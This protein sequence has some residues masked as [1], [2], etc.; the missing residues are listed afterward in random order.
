[1]GLM[2]KKILI[3]EMTI[4]IDVILRGMLHLVGL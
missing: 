4:I 2:F 3:F 1:M